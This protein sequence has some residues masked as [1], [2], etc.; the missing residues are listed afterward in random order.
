MDDKDRQLTPIRADLVPVGSRGVQP[1]TMEDLFR[2]C[3]YVADSGYAPKGMNTP[4][5]CLVA[6]Q[7]GMEL[8]LQA[9]QSLQLV[10]VVNG[11]PGLAGKFAFA[12]VRQSGKAKSLEFGITGDGDDK[13]AWM[14]SERKDIPG[15]QTTQFSV[16]DAKRAKL[17]TKGGSWSDYP[18]RM[19]HWRAAGFHFTDYYSDVLLGMSIIEELNDY[20]TNGNAEPLL[21]PPVEPD[22]LLIEADEAEDAE[23][24]APPADTEPPTSDLTDEKKAQI[25]ADETA[26]AEPGQQRLL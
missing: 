20:P 15:A 17:W 25:V 1:Q 3:K 22:P 23:T 13:Y 4:E 7:C 5:K 12:L 8:G 21:A 18:D 14:T 6:M 11:H 10:H 26:E 24:D 9:M 19:L 2:L 16:A